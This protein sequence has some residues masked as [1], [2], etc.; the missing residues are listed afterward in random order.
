MRRDPAPRGG[1]TT[2]HVGFALIAS[3]WQNVLKRDREEGVPELCRVMRIPE[4]GVVRIG[5]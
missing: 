2:T 4:E 5:W 1:A 3:F